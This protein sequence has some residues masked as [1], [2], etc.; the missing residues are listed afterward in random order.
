MLRFATHI[1]AGIASN[2]QIQEILESAILYIIPVMDVE[3]FKNAKPGQYLYTFNTDQMI[4]DSKQ[5]IIDIFNTLILFIGMKDIYL[6][7][8]YFMAV[9][10]Q[11]E[12]I[13]MRTMGYFG[14]EEGS[15][16]ENFGMYDT[17]D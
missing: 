11:G 15:L 7:E 14:S 9:F 12:C 3:G 16:V 10:F 17:G 2:D 6:F 8:K 1:A 5:G 4:S 13:L